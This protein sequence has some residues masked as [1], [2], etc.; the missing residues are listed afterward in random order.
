MKDRVLWGYIRMTASKI[1][2][3]A[4]ALRF[5]M[6]LKNTGN[7]SHGFPIQDPVFKRDS[8]RLSNLMRNF[9]N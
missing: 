3:G 8:N 2:P 9:Q 4:G 5:E 1:N 6:G 7:K